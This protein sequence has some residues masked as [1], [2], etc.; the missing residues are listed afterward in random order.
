MVLPQ[1]GKPCTREQEEQQR[2]QQ[3]LSC[4][5]PSNYSNRSSSSSVDNVL[6]PCSPRPQ[7]NVILPN[8]APLPEVNLSNL[9]SSGTNNFAE[10]F[11][12]SSSNSSN[13]AASSGISSLGPMTGDS[14]LVALP[15]PPL[16]GPSE[17]DRS[18]LLP[19]TAASPRSKMSSFTSL[20]SKEQ[21]RNIHQVLVALEVAAQ[22]AQEVLQNTTPPTLSLPPYAT[23]SNH[24]ATHRHPI[25]A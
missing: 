11:P 13:T 1:M 15:P 2:R 25:V 9:S 5:P 17:E 12:F 16:L 21:Q 6:P 24:G 10:L 3:R 22:G 4:R 20:L 23:V 18:P 14:L 8:Y 19:A 7:H